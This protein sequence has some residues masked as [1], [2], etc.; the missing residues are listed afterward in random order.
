M[1]GIGMTVAPPGLRWLTQIPPLH[2]VY[3]MYAWV[4]VALPLTQAAGRGVAALS[5]SGVRRILV[6][7]LGV[8]L[9]GMLCALP[10]SY[11][12]LESAC[13]TSPPLS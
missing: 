4:L 6:V 8:I 10:A 5:T 12:P 3:S 1:L 11:F 13:S 9:V 7:A 2:F